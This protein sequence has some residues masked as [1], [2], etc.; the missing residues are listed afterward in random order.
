MLQDQKLSI[1]GMNMNIARKT[2][3]TKRSI[4][5]KTV[6]VAGSACASKFL[7]IVRE[8]LMVRFLG[9]SVAA[10]AFITAWAIPN[11]LRKIFAEGALSVAYIPALVKM[12]KEGRSNDACGLLTLGF[13]FFEGIVLLLCFFVM[14]NSHEVVWFM[15]PGFSH[16]Q[17]VCAMPYLQ[18]LMPFIFFISCS[19]LL[20]G[21]LQTVGHF[22]VPAASPILLNGIFIGALFACI[23]YNFTVYTL[24]YFILAAGIAQFLWHLFAF[25]RS[26]LH[27]GFVT[28][29]AKKAFPDVFVKFLN[30]L[31]SMS[32][33]ELGLLIDKQFASTLP[34]GSV[35]LIYY[36]NR[37]MG[38]PLTVFVTAFSTILLPH[39][40][41][42]VMYAPKRLYFYLLES[43]KLVFWVTIPMTF[44]MIFFAQ[45][46]F[47]TIFLSDKFPLDR[48][49]QAGMALS[50]FMVGLFFF[51]LNRILLSIYYAL[52]NT[53]IPT[54]IS[55]IGIAANIILNWLLIDSL[56]IVGLALATVCAAAIQTVIYLICLHKYMRVSLPYVYFIHFIM[57]YT[58]QLVVTIVPFL[59]I[60]YGMHR[61]IIFL[62]NPYIEFLFL[63]TVAFWLWVGPLCIAFFVALYFFRATFSVG[64][65][66]LD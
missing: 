62:S 43:A 64:L 55:L 4:L 13:L 58:L 16:E 56:Q 36:A 54:I 9:I 35:A 37:F 5:R 50:A 48:I 44:L 66:F 33:M 23:H 46:I 15:A 63:Q 17:I 28:M 2:D 10:D 20:A 7:A 14:A 45:D 38:I 3:L 8:V 25:I 27:I 22:F 12:V 40:S 47:V 61:F 26:G 31:L 19:A 1:T 41:H 57:R 51:S 49:N 60:Y 21:A 32:A 42:M 52:H 65:Y 39:L 29:G 53:F 34:A 59:L 30:C 24:C 18:I 6:Q 11:S